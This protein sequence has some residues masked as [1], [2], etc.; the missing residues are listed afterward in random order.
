MLLSQTHTP[1]V[2]VISE[3]FLKGSLSIP[4]HDTRGVKRHAGSYFEY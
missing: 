4:E 3:I 2:H 1:K